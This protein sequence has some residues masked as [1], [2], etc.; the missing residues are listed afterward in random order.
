MQVQIIKWRTLVFVY[1]GDL[2]QMQ[3]TSGANQEMQTAITSGK[4]SAH[5]CVMGAGVYAGK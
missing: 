2:L 5:S 1:N 4:P 3:F